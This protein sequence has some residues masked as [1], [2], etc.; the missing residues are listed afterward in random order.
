M[1]NNLK[2]TLTLRVYINLKGMTGML[3]INPHVWG[4]AYK[5]DNCRDM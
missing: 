4:H 5:H 2:H 3:I 1:Y